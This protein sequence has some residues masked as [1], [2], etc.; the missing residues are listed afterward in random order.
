MAAGYNGTAALAGG[1]FSPHPKISTGAGDHFNGGFLSEYAD[2]FDLQAALHA[3]SA[4]AKYYVDNA[5]SPGI[6]QVRQTR[7]D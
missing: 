4:A 2:S 1:Y 6:L 7:L 5:S 3:G